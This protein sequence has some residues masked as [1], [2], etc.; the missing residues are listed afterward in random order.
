MMVNEIS[1]ADLEVEAGSCE[2][3]CPNCFAAHYKALK[4]ARAG[5]V[6]G[7][8]LAAQACALNNATGPCRCAQRNKLP[9]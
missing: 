8:K 4:K 2:Y 1:D 3:L 9:R 7:L 5:G 6:V